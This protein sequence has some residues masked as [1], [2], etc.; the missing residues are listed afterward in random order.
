MDRYY[1]AEV[2]PLPI[3]IVLS[4]HS[5]V[6][7]IGHFT[8]SDGQLRIGHKTK[9]QSTQ[10]IDDVKRFTHTITVLMVLLHVTE[11]T[12]QCPPLVSAGARILITVIPRF[13]SDMVYV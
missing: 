6:D 10:H 7:E 11:L 4:P 2:V 5:L 12:S 1:D 13:S 3:T 8:H 9:H